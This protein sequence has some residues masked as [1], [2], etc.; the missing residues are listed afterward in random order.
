MLRFVDGK[1]RELSALDTILCDQKKGL[2]LERRARLLRVDA[3]AQRAMWGMYAMPCEE[4]ATDMCD[5]AVLLRDEL[6]LASEQEH[7]AL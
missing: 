6:A 7:W 3:A 2:H 5:V 1:M 4:A